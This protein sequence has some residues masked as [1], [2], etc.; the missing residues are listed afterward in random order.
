LN[1]TTISAQ[2]LTEKKCSDCHCT[3]LIENFCRPRANNLAHEFKVCNQCSEQHKKN[4]PEKKDLVTRKKAKLE[5]SQSTSSSTASV[6]LVNS[7]MENLDLLSEAGSFLEEQSTDVLQ[8]E[9]NIDGTNNNQDGDVDGFC[10]S[11]N[12]VQE[13]VERQFHDAET[14]GEPTRLAFE[15]ELESELLA[16]VA[17]D[18]ENL[19][20]LD[21]KKI[22]ENFKELTRV[23]LVHL[24]AGSGYYW[25]SRILHLNSRKKEFSGCATA[26][27]RCTQ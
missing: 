20:S 4:K 13:Y 19:Q 3:K 27:L 21:Q 2:A 23:L 26:Y 15:I 18:Q 1:A 10:Y 24:E 9:E 17:L 11:L 7:T 22:K 8:P 6:S 12:E 14:L 16:D 25:E 5:S